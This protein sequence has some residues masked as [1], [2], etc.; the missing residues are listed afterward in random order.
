MSYLQFQPTKTWLRKHQV[1]PTECQNSDCVCIIDNINHNHQGF[2]VG[3]YD[4]NGDLD[5]L[6]LC[7]VAWDKESKEL[8]LQNALLHPQ[9]ASQLAMFLNWGV[10]AMWGML[11]EYRKQIGDMLRK[12]TRDVRQAAKQE[13]EIQESEHR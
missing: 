11:P 6:S 3:Y 5:M 9:E 4:R 12:R 7:W 8:E 1:R 13:Q 2:C 10:V